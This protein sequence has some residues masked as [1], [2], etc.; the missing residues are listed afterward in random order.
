MVNK[1]FAPAAMTMDRLESRNEV[2]KRKN[3]KFCGRKGTE[4]QSNPALFLHWYYS[5]SFLPS[6][7]ASVAVQVAASHRS[8]G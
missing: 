4:I 8:T 2:G 3:K 6:R 7:R 1:S 5:R